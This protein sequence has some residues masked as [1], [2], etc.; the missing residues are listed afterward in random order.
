MPDLKKVLE[1]YV[2]TANNPKYN[3]DFNVINSK[4]PE[5]KNYDKKLLEE[6]VATANNE[7]YNSDFNIINS[8]FPEFF[9][10]PV[11]KKN[12]NAPT[13]SSGMGVSMA[14]KGSDR[15]VLGNYGISTKPKQKEATTGVPVSI[16]SP[17]LLKQSGFKPKEQF[18]NLGNLNK[19]VVEKV[20]TVT[21]NQQKE[22]QK[23][24]GGPKGMLEAANDAI[25]STLT[26]GTASLVSG[27]AGLIGGLADLTIDKTPEQ[28][29][30]A[31]FLSPE[32]FKSKTPFVQEGEVADP[33]WWSNQGV[34]DKLFEWSN[35]LSEI[36]QGES[37][38]AKSE[39]GVVNTKDSSVDAI[40][41]GNYK[42]AAK[43]LLVEI[44]TVIP[45]LAVVYGSGGSNVALGGVS[46]SAAGSDMTR[47]YGEDQ[48]ISTTD[49]IQGVNIGLINY[50]SEK[51][52]GT[53]IAAAKLLGQK[54]SGLL[55]TSGRALQQQIRNEGVDAVKGKFIRSFGEVL[56]ATGKGAREE[57]FE[58]NLVSAVSFLIDSVDEDKFN[59]EGYEQL[60]KGMAQ[61]TLIAGPLGG[62]M[63]FMAAQ[64]SFKPLTKEEKTKI[65]RY[66]EVIDSETASNDVKKIAQAKL[67]A[68]NNGAAVKAEENYDK[69][70]ELPLEERVLVMD[71]MNKVK[72]LEAEYETLS[73][74]DMKDSVIERISQLD[75]EI[76]FALNPKEA[77]V[78]GSARGTEA[79]TDVESTAK[80]LESL[81]KDKDGN[82]EGIELSPLDLENEG[83]VTWDRKDSKSVAEAYHKAK[84]DNSNPELVNAVEK[85]LGGTPKVGE[86]VATDKAAE[87]I[88][89]PETL[90][91]QEN[92]PD[93][94]ISDI[95]DKRVTMN[96]KNGNLYQEENGLVVFNEDGGRKTE[97]G[98]INDIS[99]SPIS[100][101]KIDT[102]ESVVGADK[103]GNITVRGES[104]I[105]PYSNPTAAINYDN[106]GNVVSVNME[107]SN[108]SKRAFRGNIAEDVAY[109]IHLK[110]ISKDNERLNSFEEYIN[111]EQG[112]QE[113]NDG[114]IQGASET[115][116]KQ[117]DA[118]VPEKAVA[119]VP[120]AP[121]KPVTL[122][123][124]VDQLRADEQAEYDAMSDPNNEAARKKIYDKYDKKIKPLLKEIEKA[125]T[126]ADQTKVEQ[127]ASTSGTSPKNIRDLYKV[128]R[129]LF[130][131]DR[132]K[133]FASAVAMDRMVGTM[134]KRAGIKK[135]EMYGRLKFEKA[136]E[137]FVKNLSE[138]GKVLWQI[139]GENANLSQTIKDNLSSAREMELA[140]K[141][142]KTIRIATGWE[143]GADKKWKFEI[144]SGKLKGEPRTVEG[145]LSDLLDNKEL[146]EMYPQL[147]DV[148]VS[149]RLNGFGTGD[150]SS[151]GIVVNGGVRDM[152]SILNHEVQHAIQGI[153]GFARGGNI[154][155]MTTKD[156][157]LQ[158]LA[159]PLNFPKLDRQ[160]RI[161]ARQKTIEKGLKFSE[162]FY[163]D[164]IKDNPDIIEDAIERLEILNDISP[165]DTYVKLIT[166]L[167]YKLMDM[168][169]ENI[170]FVKYKKLAGE[171]EA[172][173][174][175]KRMD[176]SNEQKRDTLLSETEDIARDEQIVLFQKDDKARGAAMVSM[177]GQS[178]IYAL[179][180]PN[181]STPLH[182]LAHV[183]E[184][185]L[186]DAEKTEVMKSAGTKSWDTKTSEHF[187]R[188]FEK[189]LSEGKSPITAL[190]KVFAKFK[191]WLTDIYNGI[192]NSD[193]DIQLNKPM[194]D[195][196]ASMLGTT[197]EQAAKE[198]EK[199]YKD[200]EDAIIKSGRRNYWAL[201]KKLVGNRKTNIEKIITATEKGIFANAAVE[202][203]SG[204]MSY[205]DEQF[206]EAR[207]RLYARALM[208]ID[209]RFGKMSISINKAITNINAKAKQALDEVMFHR[210]V[211]EIDS[212][213]DKKNKKLDAE[214]AQLGAKKKSTTSTLEKAKISEELKKLK[215]QRKDRIEHPRGFNKELSEA[216]IE[217]IKGR[218]GTE[219]FNDIEK[220][221]NT[222]FEIR[223]EIL[224]KMV[225]EGLISKDS[226]YNLSGDD[227]IERRFLEYIL[228]DYKSYG[229]SNS[230]SSA[231]IK[232]LSEGS[233]GLVLM[234]SEVLLHAAY[235]SIENR[236]AQNKANRALAEAV[237][238][239][240]FDK[241]VVMPAEFEKN[242]NGK[243]KTDKYGNRVLKPAPNGFELIPFYENGEKS[244]VY[245]RTNEASEWN[246]SVKIQ[247]M[248][249][250]ISVD[251]IFKTVFFVKTL[252]FFATLANPL[253]AYGNM[254]RD[255]A[256]VLFLSSTY[257]NNILTAA[258]RLLANFSNKV[259]QYTALKTSGIA[260]DNFR[261]LVDDY[262]KYGGKFEFLH[263]DGKSSNLY[264]N[265]LNKKRYLIQKIGGG[266]YNLFENALGFPGEISEISMRLAVFEKTRDTLI[267]KYGGKSSINAAQMADINIL[268]A[269][270][271]RAIM[272]Y[273]K[274]G[275]ATKWLDNFSPYLNASVVG[276]VSDVNYIKKNPKKFAAKIAMF[277]ANVAAITLYNLMNS[278][279]E[280]RK[281]IPDYIKNNN[282]VFF[283][284]G[285]NKD[286]KK[287]Y[288]TVP[289]YQGLQ[290]FAS[291]FEE[292]TEIAYNM[293]IEKP[294]KKVGEIADRLQETISTWS[295]IPAS[296]RGLMLKMPPLVQAS[297][298]YYSNYD[299]F[300]DS[301]IEYRQG[302]VPTKDE[303]LDN[304]K[305]ARTYRVLGQMSSK[306]GD[307]FAISPSRAQNFTEK[308]I[309]SP[310]TNFVV[311]GIY[312]ITDWITQEHQIP[313]EIKEA[314][315][316]TVKASVKNKFIR[317]VDPEYLA[318]FKSKSNTIEQEITA[319]SEFQQ[320]TI[321]L[322]VSNGEPKDKIVDFIK[323]LN[324]SPEVKVTRLKKAA[325]LIATKDDAKTVPFYG[326]LMDVKYIDGLTFPTP[327]DKAVKAFDR[328]GGVDPNSEDFLQ[329][330]ESAKKLK[331]ITKGVSEER[332]RREYQ[333]IFAQNQTEGKRK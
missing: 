199:M 30:K 11:E 229:Q 16:A 85:L 3:S 97:I 69:V 255:F 173:N 206:M 145:K 323:G 98:N 20:K 261:Q 175:Q 318:K 96:G 306:L 252:K 131:L 226:A 2:A 33:A 120:S 40:L 295:P 154:Q 158:G 210:R 188:G 234:D 177:D 268:A 233:T 42:D 24:A 105:N 329:I 166:A 35:K 246:D 294:Q 115:G 151:R 27:A 170:A 111:S 193:I 313:R 153:E 274:G 71:K 221:A 273:N 132:V 168:G 102:Q 5:L 84:A 262:T 312:G 172:R 270:A 240:K 231:Q 182:E 23:M 297:Y 144:S 148:N 25:V 284:P 290:P 277:G 160:D 109:Q 76:N 282:F 225:E 89:T 207:K 288:R 230:L 54:L 18:S 241:S 180:D 81:P 169:G 215:S 10:K 279:E 129:D 258:P 49:F 119:P 146:F 254:F 38:A 201:F 159:S 66:Q 286:G 123:D 227:Y 45:Q 243:Y 209:K 82:I 143:K 232:S 301:K 65:E 83:I 265:T 90:T 245:M 190:D 218:I 117:S 46:A 37:E 238:E 156:D 299:L 311:G 142:A 164:V 91:T 181:V 116:T 325:D 292:S 110:E 259:T 74:M 7:E 228:E 47:Q 9:G 107:T 196:Y 101:F 14:G 141:D 140:G 287:E 161:I 55:G 176:M 41:K 80:A 50:I 253:F 17:E 195:I 88:A 53:D 60:L 320:K 333:R 251:N 324:T 139:I 298:A 283:I 79:A 184:H 67:D 276:F 296:M 331:V 220:R 187:A 1:E 39:L 197:P 57:V 304:D 242:L 94:L 285:K 300:R 192:K 322:M 328:F 31:P 303:G 19:E 278:D 315:P 214:I 162:V 125:D 204:S 52:F 269:N 235:R 138:K 310:T 264:K 63:S 178:V 308:L 179:T 314:K 219:A 171:V 330:I 6:Y 70:M 248:I 21:Q 13:A 239:Q 92:V 73:D 87:N 317:E 86:G 68:I 137:D 75:E 250:D 136:N 44:G 43:S 32:W 114:Q 189:Y 223:G 165:N 12:P 77:E 319:E 326:E 72:S 48:D 121:T 289:K 224:D 128:N 216:A 183:F 93:V 150:Y 305:T 291:M 147:K 167:D 58:E 130:G 266:A 61:N 134:A 64:A 307:G 236:V 280:D 149:L 272:D 174:V 28:S 202:N 99:D 237:S 200:S 198:S 59:K 316:S 260:S 249:G 152:L 108:G 327:E 34:R 8:K 275:L 186:T 103:N 62:G 78:Q 257:D 127:V 191:E 213:T 267:D 309:T 56:K 22:I 106:K 203:V 100:D 256:K 217:G 113:I 95:I 222:Y 293:Y 124:Q 247:V 281:N 104:Y 112:Q 51:I 4:F 321:K 36:A 163:F 122:Q 155:E 332:F 126:K 118:V 271:S 133:A 211:I 157:I 302:K 15:S 194:R 135:S 205:A 212:R 244:G 29:K 208:K 185:Y 263:K 26:S